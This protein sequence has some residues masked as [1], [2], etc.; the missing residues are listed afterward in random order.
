M[1]F[2]SRQFS[3]GGRVTSASTSE[4]LSF[5]GRCYKKRPTAT[6]AVTGFF[7]LAIGDVVRQQVVERKREQHSIGE[8]LK[9]GALGF[10]W[11]GPVLN[12]WYTL[13][14][15][16]IKVPG[17]R[18]IVLKIACDQI[19]FAPFIIFSIVNFLK[20]PRTK[21]EF[22]E[23]FNEEYLTVLKTNYKFWP[24]V[25]FITFSVI[26]L[27]LRVIFV[28]TVSIGWNTFISFTMFGKKK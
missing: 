4:K 13:L 1:R 12:A 7:L 26:P 10:V 6:S 25:Q 18:G 16:K 3:S 24:W 5:Y 15:R 28:N 20:S 17:V 22:K 19:M 23:V 8:T 21:E 9:M 27:S 2:I 14:D 11:V